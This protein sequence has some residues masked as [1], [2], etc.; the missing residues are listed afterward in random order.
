M[1]KKNSLELNEYQVNESHLEM[2]NPV[3]REFKLDGIPSEMYFI[4]MMQLDL[5]SL[6][7]LTKTCTFFQK[8]HKKLQNQWDYIFAK[9]IKIH[10]LLAKNLSRIFPKLKSLELENCNLLNK[11]FRTIFGQLRHIIIRKDKGYKSDSDVT[12]PIIL[13]DRLE[14]FYLNYEHSGLLTSFLLTKVPSI[15]TKFCKSLKSFTFITEDSFTTFDFW[16]PQVPC[17][18]IFKCTARPVWRCGTSCSKC[19]LSKLKEIEFV[20]LLYPTGCNP[21]AQLSYYD[22]HTPLRVDLTPSP[23]LTKLTFPPNSCINHREIELR[24]NMK[25]NI[26]FSLQSNR[27]N[28]RSEVFNF[29]GKNTYTVKLEIQNKFCN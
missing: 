16:H 9:N 24:S 21:L 4:I 3:L 13:P 25:Q 22:L 17:L 10:I 28:F 8:L 27:F 20:P 6:V 29:T 26:E 1:E 12:V 7:Q 18:E 5:F 14:S 23:N 19:W 11:D 2:Q 15:N